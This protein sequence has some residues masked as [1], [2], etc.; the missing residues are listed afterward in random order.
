MRKVNS[1]RLGDYAK[2]TSDPPISEL[3]S[4][5]EQSPIPTQTDFLCVRCP[6]LYQ[7]ILFQ[8]LTKAL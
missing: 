8:V 1:N 7:K 2:R 5:S 3:P 6:I 4:V